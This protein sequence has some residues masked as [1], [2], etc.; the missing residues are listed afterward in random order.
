MAEVSPNSSSL[1]RKGAAIR[2][3]GYQRPLGSTRRPAVAPP[4]KP[5]RGETASARY[6]CR[7]GLSQELAVPPA[8][9]DVAAVEDADFVGSASVDSRWAMTTVV[10]PSHSVRSERWIACSDSES[11]PRSLRPEG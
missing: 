7:C 1:S 3:G 4:A 8:L 11:A 6:C 9:D 2:I 5:R 10:R